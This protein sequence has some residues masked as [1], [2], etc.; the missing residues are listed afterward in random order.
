LCSSHHSRLL[1]A[2]SN[3]AGWGFSPARVQL[4]KLGWTL[5]KTP[6]AT[7]VLLRRVFVASMH[8]SLANT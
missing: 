6:L 4:Q 5:Q 7:V 8:V 1:A 3:D 2:T